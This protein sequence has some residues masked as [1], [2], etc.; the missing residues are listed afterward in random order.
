M[1]KQGKLNRYKLR[2]LIIVFLTVLTACSTNSKSRLEQHNEGKSDNFNTQKF[3]KKNDLNKLKSNMTY[4]I[5]PS[6]YAQQFFNKNIFTLNRDSTIDDLNLIRDDLNNKFYSEWTTLI[7]EMN[8]AVSNLKKIVA[9]QKLSEI[10]FAQTDSVE[11][12]NE[13]IFNQ[14]KGIQN[15]EE[16]SSFVGSL[17]NTYYSYDTTMNLLKAELIYLPD[18]LEY[19][20]YESQ[21]IVVQTYSE[22]LHKYGDQ[23]SAEKFDKEN[24]ID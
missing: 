4:L 17:E 16:L 14:L 3:D 8:K 15:Q 13:E 22:A 12:K 21:R 11:E 2:I 6:V 23:S 1:P 19:T 24:L 7:D 5:S 20:E 18:D 9:D 10:L